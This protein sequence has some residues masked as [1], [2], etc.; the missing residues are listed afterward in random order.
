[1]LSAVVVDNSDDKLPGDGLF[2]LATQLGLYS[3]STK[4]KNMRV[5]W[6]AELDRVYNY[7][8]SH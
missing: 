8:A 1:M 4:R 6:K 3:Y 2:K 5:F 7:W